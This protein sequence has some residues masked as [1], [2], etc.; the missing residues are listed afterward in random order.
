VDALPPVSTVRA[1]RVEGSREIHL[2]F[3]G[4]DASSG[5]ANYDIYIQE[6]G[7]EWQAFGN[8]YDDTETILADSSK[9]YNFYVLANDNVGNTESK[10]PRAE[11]TVGIN[12]LVKSKGQFSLWPVPATDMVY[13]GGLRQS[14][15]YVI[16]DL[17][18]KKVLSG[19]L[20]D[21]SNSINI[22]KLNGG[23]YILN[24]Y[25]NRSFETFKLIKTQGR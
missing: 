16:S 6:E 18:G 15:N 7:G 4:S 9:Q 12:E 14:N 3:T 13:I 1:T 11:T 25:N 22:Q 8:A 5:I 19:I 2:T 17:S 20:S 24:I 21:T 10:N 23:M